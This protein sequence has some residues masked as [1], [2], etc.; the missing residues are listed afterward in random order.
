MHGP[1]Y[2][3]GGRAP[4]ESLAGT[5][6]TVHAETQGLV[7][8]AWSP[9]PAPRVLPVG[10]RGLGAEVPWGPAR[11]PVHGW[12]AD[13]VAGCLLEALMRASD[14]VTAHMIGHQLCIATHP[15][16][17]ERCMRPRGHDRWTG[18]PDAYDAHAVT[19]ITWT[20]VPVPEITTPGMTPAR[21]LEHQ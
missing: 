7:V 16:R 5:V 21:H 8:N 11:P 13:L 18:V 6:V 1:A 17:G 3:P 20:T 15:T 12:L 10:P 9:G 19:G 2:G 14:L 4:V